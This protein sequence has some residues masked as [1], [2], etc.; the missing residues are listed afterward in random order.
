MDW[1]STQLL[2]PPKKSVHPKQIKKCNVKRYARDSPAQ[3][4]ILGN[5]PAGEVDTHL[6]GVDI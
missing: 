5:C 1:L 6:H 2:P 3:D 4:A